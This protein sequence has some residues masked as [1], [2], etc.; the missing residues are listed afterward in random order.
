VN[1]KRPVTLKSVKSGTTNLGNFS[2]TITY[3]PAKED[4]IEVKGMKVK[5]LTPMRKD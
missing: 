5:L 1:Q 2:S 3:P 4:K